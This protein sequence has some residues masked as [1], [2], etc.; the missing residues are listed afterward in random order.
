METSLA[1]AESLPETIVRRTLIAC[2]LSALALLAMMAVVPAS[3]QP[4]GDPV[5][6]KTVRMARATWDT[7]WFQAEVYRLLLMRLGYRVE[8]PVTME[9]PDFYRAVA[10]G[11]VDLWV[12]G[13]FPTHDGLIE[14]DLVERIGTQVDAGA[15]QGYFVDAATAGAYRITN[16]G[17]L[18]DPEVAALFDLDADGRADLIGCETGWTC[19]HIIDHH[20]EA[21]GLDGTVEQVQGDY[22]P[23]IAETIARFEAGQPVLY[24]TWTPNWTVGELVPGRDVVWLETPFPSLPPDQSAFL[25]HTSIPG[26]PGCANDPCQVGWPPNDIRAVANSGFLDANPS[27]RRLLERVVISLEDISLQNAHMVRDQGDPE[28]IRRHAE[29]WVEQN[30]DVVSAWIEAADP[31]A[32]ALDGSAVDDTAAGGML[33]VAARTL[34]PF[35]IY[36][37]GTY[38]GFE[39]DLVELIAARLGM[40]V[41]IYAVDTAAKQMDDISRGV[42]DVGLGGVVITGPREE[43]ID[44]SLPLLDTGLTIMTPTSGSQAVWDRIGVF[45]SA[46]WGSDLPWLLVVFAVAVLV[47]A[48]L[49]WWLERKHNPDFAV[50]YGRGIW[51]S[52]YWSVVTMSTV[53]YGDK[54]A[55]GRLG[56]LFALI[57]IALGTLVFASFTAAIASSLAVNEL[58]S[59]IDGPADLP[60]H[61]IATV[62]DSAGYDYLT[63]I[64]VGPVVV[65]NLDDAY[66]QLAQGEVDA[67]VFDAPVLQFHVSHRGEGTVTTVGPL[68][69]K[70]QYGLMVSEDDTALRER[71]DLALLDLIESGIYKQI[72][73]RWFG[74][75]G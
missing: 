12:N 75:L 2:S 19:S 73:D 9:N 70:V 16:L 46:I 33:H 45:L 32:I 24:Y 11:E 3:G 7:G 48:H 65:H 47:A 55:R 35:V 34:P 21:F 4:D 41:E 53:G 50:P 67:V 69:D 66:D 61:R 56:R 14:E 38:S 64:G 74:A 63:G 40:T 72:H 54:V 71:I 15:L 13:W 6:A 42:A 17:D 30:S 59:N 52:F 43:A 10:A 31:E 8:G 58:R 37:Q 20:L 57:W 51:D 68:F 26:I 1:L 36:N 60:G 23:L 18:A 44:F 5:E 39:V 25:D 49:I 22:S 29:Q 28:D 27:V 62:H